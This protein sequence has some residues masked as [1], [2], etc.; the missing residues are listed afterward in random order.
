MEWLSLEVTLKI[1][2]IQ[3]LCHAQG[4]QP[5]D[6]AAQ[7]PIQ[8]VLKHLQGCSTH[9]FFGQSVPVP[10]CPLS[11]NNFFLISNLN[12]P[13]FSLKLFLLVLSLLGCIKSQSPS[14][15]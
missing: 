1:I 14:K 2:N 11:E 10:H 8:P 13:S 9:N 15:I 12:I 6:Q 7:G 4:C 3:L 5:L